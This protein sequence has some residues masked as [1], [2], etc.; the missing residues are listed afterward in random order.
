MVAE[1]AADV[2]WRLSFRRQGRGDTG[3]RP[4]TAHVVA[5]TIGIGALR[6]VAGHQRVHETRV[7]LEQLI[8]PEAQPF[9]RV[10]AEVG[11]EDV[12]LGDHAV[13]RVAPAL[14]LEVEHHTALAPIVEIERR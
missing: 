1:A 13:Q 6:A 14:F 4:E 10:D 2:R 8:R 9:E 11:E 12:G 5:G 7:G 3:T